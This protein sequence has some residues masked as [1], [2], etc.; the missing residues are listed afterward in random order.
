MCVVR[1][2]VLRLR[3]EVLR[4]PSSTQLDF[5]LMISRSWQYISCHWDACSNHSAINDFKR[6]VLSHYLRGLRWFQ[7]HG[8]SDR[9]MH[10]QLICLVQVRLRIE[11]L[12]TPSSTKLRFE[13]MISRSWQYISC[14]WD[15][16][17]NHVHSAISDFILTG[18]GVSMGYHIAAFLNLKYPYARLLFWKLTINK[19]CFNENESSKS[20]FVYGSRPT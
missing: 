14:H 2:V 4:T 20:F 7:M 5:D 11:V 19:F 10:W 6:N 16:C 15:A 17:S 1:V 13:L 9:L 12:H 3:T 8:L 18:P